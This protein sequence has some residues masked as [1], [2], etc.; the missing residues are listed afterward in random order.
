MGRARVFV[1]PYANGICNRLMNGSGDDS[2]H[3]AL[4]ARVSDIFCAAFIFPNSQVGKAQA[5]GVCISRS[6]RDWGTM[7]WVSTAGSAADL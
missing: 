4:A 2:S 7:C 5:F 6:S 1:V 3:K